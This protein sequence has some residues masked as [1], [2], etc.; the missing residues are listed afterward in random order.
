MSAPIPDLKKRP[1]YPT[2]QIAGANL[3]MSAQVINFGTG[4]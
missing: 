3:I 1:D 4:F 2:G